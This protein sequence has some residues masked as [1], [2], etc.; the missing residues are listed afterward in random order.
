MVPGVAVVALSSLTSAV[1]I[2][3]PVLPDLHEFD[4]EWQQDLL[5]RVPVVRLVSLRRVWENGVKSLVVAV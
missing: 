4:L 3:D 5:A 2:A 1:E